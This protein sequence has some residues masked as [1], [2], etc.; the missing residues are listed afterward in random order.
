MLLNKGVAALKKIQSFWGGNPLIY[1][2]A[3]GSI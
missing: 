3:V 1:V 2:D